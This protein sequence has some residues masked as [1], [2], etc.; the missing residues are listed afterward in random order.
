MR[1]FVG[2]PCNSLL[3]K[4]FLPSRRD[5]THAC[6][7]GLSLLIKERPT[8]LKDKREPQA[9]KLITACGEKKPLTALD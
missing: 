1:F 5:W 8:A 6:G 4:L 9:E 2:S 3:F 7:V